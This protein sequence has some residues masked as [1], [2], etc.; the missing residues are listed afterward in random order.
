[1]ITYA[2]IVDNYFGLDRKTLF[3]TETTLV[4]VVLKVHNPIH[5]IIP[6]NSSKHTA[7]LVPKVGLYFSDVRGEIGC[8]NSK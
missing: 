6:P 7:I 2:Q 1:M 8:K 4:N 5:N 3:Y